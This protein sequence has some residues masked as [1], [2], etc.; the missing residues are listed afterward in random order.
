M[1]G[2]AV[3]WIAVLLAGCGGSD[4][5][6]P[7]DVEPGDYRRI[8]SL[9]PSITEV[10]YAMGAQARIAG[11]TSFCDYPE[12]ARTLPDV[13]DFLKPNMEAVIALEPDL[14]ILAPTGT[15]LRKSYDNFASLGLKVLVVWNNTVEETLTAILTIGRTLCMDE[16]ASL[17]VSGIRTSIQ[18]ETARLASAP[19]VRVLWVVG[20]RPLVAVGSLTYQS[21]ILAMAGGINVIPD[22]Q[23]AWPAINEE[24]VLEANPA[25]IIDS[26]MG[27]ESGGPSHDKDTPW[28]R[29][30]SVEAVIKGR[31]KSLRHDALYRPGPRMAEALR[32]LG[33]TLHPEYYRE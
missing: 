33:A 10:L 28:D 22:D 2:K 15:L 18:T 25:V 8:I 23:G 16:A 14:I 31:V 11:V 17:V 6:V 4:R 29:L 32:I 1:K 13:G 9:T 21:E 30:S 7:P 12:A 27:R 5:F 19:K 20:H 26:A 24:F 3:F